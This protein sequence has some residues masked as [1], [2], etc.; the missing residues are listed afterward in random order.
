MCIRDRVTYAVGETRHF[1]FGPGEYLLHDLEN[2][3]DKPLAF[4]TVE[5]RRAAPPQSDP[6]HL[7]TKG[8]VS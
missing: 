4:L 7:V 6:A 1:D 3:G 2:I 5:F 8:D